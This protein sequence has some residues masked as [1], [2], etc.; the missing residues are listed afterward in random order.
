MK[1]PLFEASHFMPVRPPFYGSGRNISWECRNKFTSPLVYADDS[2][3]DAGKF[4]DKFILLQ[5]DRTD[6]SG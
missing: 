4:G 5:P 2:K 3:S 1:F 6:D